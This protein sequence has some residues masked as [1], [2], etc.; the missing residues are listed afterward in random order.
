[1]LEERMKRLAAVG[2]AVA[3][4]AWLALPGAG[5]DFAQQV[6]RVFD[7]IET[8][9]GKT[10]FHSI[11]ELKELGRSAA[12]DVRRGLR[13]ADP[14]V[15]IAAA[16]YLYAN[17]F[18]DEAVDTLLLVATQSR[19]AESRQT[20]AG[21]L[22]ALV[23][24]DAT[25]APRRKKEI[26]D[27]VAKAAREAEGDSTRIHL[28][29]AVWTLSGNPDA[30]RN[31]IDLFRKAEDKDARDDAALAL[32][33]MDGLL[34]PGVKDQLR[35]LAAEPSPKGRLAKA[36]LDTD[37]LLEEAQRKLERA[38]PPPADRGPK[39][40]DYDFSM[41][42]EVLDTLKQN[43][44]DPKKIESETKRLIEQA[45]RGIAGSLDAYSAYYDRDAI[46]AMREDLGSAYGGI[47][48]RVSMR[49]DR[50]GVAWLTIEE[51]I[52]SG[53]AYEAGLRSNDKIVEVEGES[54]AN[55]EL[56]D[57]VRKL[58]GQP[59]TKVKIKVFSVRWEK[60][61]DFEITRGQ[62][63]LE[64]VQYTLLPGGIGYIKQTTFG[65]EEDE[66]IA[67]AIRSLTDQGAKALVFDL[68]GNS[69]G[70]LDTSVRVANLFLD[71]NKIVVRIDAQNPK[72]DKTTHRTSRKAVTNLPL[73]V[74]VD[75]GSASASEIVAGALRDHKRATLVGE[76]TFGKGSVQRLYYLDSTG[77]E[78]AVRITIARWFLP[79]GETIEKDPQDKSGILPDVEAHPPTPDLFKEREWERLR[80]SPALEKYVE[81]VYPQNKELMRKL[82]LYDGNDVSKYPGFDD[83][84]RST[85]TRATKEEVRELLR[86]YV[87][88]RVQDDLQKEFACD[89]Q[90]D[91]VL[92]TAIREVAKTARIDVER[93]DEYKPFAKAKASAEEH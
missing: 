38:A 14:N 45:A 93:I 39:S 78:T 36:Y 4:A 47:G 30:K 7:T 8:S 51:P 60:P 71:P 86:D 62:V 92:Q 67:T 84:Y 74:L 32:A 31:L 20:A 83:F 40:G 18:R 27:K 23:K 37:R 46:K 44:H 9:K 79:N 5:Q 28:W 41:L 88:R 81:R 73:A 82:A 85:E 64:S 68:R 25:I 11:R 87:R 3:A 55:K 10:L 22:G 49:K 69:G 6:D 56:M 21:M 65:Q 15:R 13:R 77:R 16:A 26:S 19:E 35:A 59:G 29:L 70:Y 48:A 53:P 66:K 75:G 80:A 89:F 17:D 58:R 90:T 42:A 91:T 33:E 54:T 63:T 61:K 52:F 12:E 24:E 1:L 50:G 43:Y 57:L 2:F 72:T 76:K 34:V